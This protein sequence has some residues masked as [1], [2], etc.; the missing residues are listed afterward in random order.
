M[1]DSSM[2]QMGNQMANA[3]SSQHPF[4]K[5]RKPA[6]PTFWRGDCSLFA[7]RS[8]PQLLS[9]MMDVDMT[10]MGTKDIERSAC[11]SYCLKERLHTGQIGVGF[12]YLQMISSLI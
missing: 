9:V 7:C 6:V 5:F 11:H 3:N 8:M 1:L 2:I 10:T 12:K 4:A